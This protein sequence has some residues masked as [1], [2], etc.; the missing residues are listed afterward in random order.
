MKEGR[1]G[2]EAKEGKEGR[3]E[4]GKEGQ[5]RQDGRGLFSLVSG[6]KS[7][8]RPYLFNCSMFSLF[9]FQ[10]FSISFWTGSGG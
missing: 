6:E 1:E 7:S 2:K 10:I 8:P 4:G 3:R 9:S 5:T